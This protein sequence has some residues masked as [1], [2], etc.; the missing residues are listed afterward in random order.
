[1]G[2]ADGA[3]VD[4]HEGGLLEVVGHL[5]TFAL[6]HG[7]HALA[8]VFVHLTPIGADEVLLTVLTHRIRLQP[9]PQARAAIAT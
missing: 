9:P 3:G 8:V 7:A 5:V 6:Q 1:M 4:E 2:V